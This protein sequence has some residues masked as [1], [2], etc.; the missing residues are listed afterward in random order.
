MFRLRLV[1]NLLYN[2]GISVSA[3]VLSLA[4]NIISIHDIRNSLWL[5]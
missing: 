4:R 1:E 5:G 3:E 2:G